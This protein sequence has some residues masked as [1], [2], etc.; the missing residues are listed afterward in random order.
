L[1]LRY[2]ET[3]SNVAFNFIVRH[4]TTTRAEAAAAAA[5]DEVTLLQERCSRA[6]AAERE[7]R[8]TLDAAERQCEELAGSHHA[9]VLDLSL[10]LSEARQVGSGGYCWPRHPTHNEPSFLNQMAT[11]DVASN[12][13]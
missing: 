12:M 13:R 9:V 6:A 5:E 7:L 4:Y 1:Q 2:D 10:Q 11:Y 8:A 3:L